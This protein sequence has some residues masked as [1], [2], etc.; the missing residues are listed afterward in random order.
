VCYSVFC[1]LNWTLHWYVILLS[2]VAG[3]VPRMLCFYISSS[4]FSEVTW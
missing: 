4:Q 3:T 1:A 2:A